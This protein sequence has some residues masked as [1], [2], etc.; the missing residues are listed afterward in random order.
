[1]K[2][3]TLEYEQ[4]LDATVGVLQTRAAAGAEP[5]TYGALSA[6]PARQGH[7]VPAHRGPMSY[8]LEDA[9]LRRSPDGSLPML[10][11]LVV[12]KAT[13][14]P[15]GGFFQ[16]ARRDHFSRPGDDTELWAREL[17]H[18]AKHYRSR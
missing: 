9:S 8:L 15:S 4:A 3:N 1:M 14:W 18:L 7:D 11:A 16:L 5:L 10:S 13:M 17:A 12:L 2:R 6:E